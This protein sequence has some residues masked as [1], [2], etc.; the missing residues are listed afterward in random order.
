MESA[1]SRILSAA[2]AA[3]AIISLGPALP[4]ASCDRPGSQTTRATSPPLFG[5]APGGVWRAAPVTRDAGALLPHRFTLASSARERQIGGLLSVPLSVG[6][7]PLGVTQHPC[8]AEFGLSS[9]RPEGPSA[10][11]SQTPCRSGPRAPSPRRALGW[12]AGRHA[13]SPRAA[14][15]GWSSSRVEPPTP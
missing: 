10:I 12:R 13:C 14:R 8:P 4:R 1:V 6:S 15:G 3:V 2:F 5:L 11:T 9:D 7:L